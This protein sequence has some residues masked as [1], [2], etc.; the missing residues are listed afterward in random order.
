[1]GEGLGVALAVLSSS[2]GGIAAGT[3]RFV[4]HNADPV[5]LGAFRYGGGFLLLLPTTLLLR[6]K[7]PQ[8]RDW[9]GVAGLGL[10]FFGL[11][12]V[13]YNIALAYTTAARGALSLST[14]PLL[15]MLVAA[16]LGIEKLTRRKTIGVLVAMAGVA[17]A[18]AAGLGAASAGAWRGDLL[19]IVAAF[20]MALYNVWSKPFIARSSAFAFTTAG[21]GAGSLVLI[22]IA[23]AG[24][25]FAATA[26]FGTPQWLAVA[27]LGSFGSA[28][29]F[30]L[31]VVALQRASP[32][33]VAATITVN[34]V[35]AATVAGLLIGE[36]FGLN[37]IIG[38]VAVGAG[39]W[40]ASTSPR[41]HNETGGSRWATR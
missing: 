33:R 2:F 20:C 28:V 22:L 4:V 26:D 1:M 37:L 7:W 41:R 6:Q 31:W 16:G 38:I 15:T 13:L 23:I 40:I 24:G 5:T 14:L 18:L 8:G 35:M 27:Y 12:P 3:T 21:M 11:F 34:P 36:P 17:S 39:I 29:A 19:M 30:S 32:T 10:L 9:A 25:G